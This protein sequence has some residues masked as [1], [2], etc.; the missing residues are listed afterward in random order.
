VSPS[1]YF[2]EV[3]AFYDFEQR[4]TEECVGTSS[5][6]FINRIFSSQFIEKYREK[7]NSSNKGLKHILQNRQLEVIA[8]ITNMY[9]KLG[10]SI[11]DFKEPF[12]KFVEEEIAS[13][14]Q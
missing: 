14:L 11:K 2:T 5:D 10:N 9:K 7:L 12:E 4:L 8:T 1:E 13:L 3:S 6:S